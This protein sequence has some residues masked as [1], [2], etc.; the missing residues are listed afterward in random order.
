MREAGRETRDLRGEQSRKRRGVVRRI[1]EHDFR[2]AG[3]TRGLRGHLGAILRQHGHHER[4]GLEI[5]R[6][7]DAL[8][9]GGIELGAVV[10][11]NDQHSAH[12]RTPRATSAATSSVTSLTRIPAT[13][14]GDGAK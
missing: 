7:A 4:R 13:R 8:R 2:D 12:E 5:E 11:R 14:G 9:R 10:L 6:A 3:E 1:D